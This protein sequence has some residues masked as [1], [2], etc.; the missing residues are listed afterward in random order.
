M[1][2]GIGTPVTYAYIS[3][4]DPITR[5][6]GTGVVVGNESM[7]GT[8]YAYAVKQDK[9]GEV[10]HIRAWNVWRIQ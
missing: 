7:V 4:Y 6:S 2:L 1:T 3:S 8:D 5:H 9:D 10:A